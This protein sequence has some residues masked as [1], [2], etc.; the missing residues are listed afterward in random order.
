MISIIVTLETSRTKNTIKATWKFLIY[1]FIIT[2]PPLWWL[3]KVVHNLFYFVAIRIRFIQSTYSVNE[4]DGQAQPV[5]ILSNPSSTNITVQV[6]SN[7]I[8]A[9][10]E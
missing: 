1:T 8:T 9:T 4:N 5:L 2:V 3:D 10:G 6:R 7:D